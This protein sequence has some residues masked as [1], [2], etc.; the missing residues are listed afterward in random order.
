M[1]RGNEYENIRYRHSQLFIEEG[2]FNVNYTVLRFENDFKRAYSVSLAGK[3]HRRFGFQRTIMKRDYYI[4]RLEPLVKW[5]QNSWRFEKSRNLTMVR[6]FFEASN[7]AKFRWFGRS[8]ATRCSAEKQIETEKVSDIL[9]Y[10]NIN[11]D[12]IDRG[13]EKKKNKGEH[14]KRIFSRIVNLRCKIAKIASNN[15]YVFLFTFNPFLKKRN[16]SLET[17]N[18][19]KEDIPFFDFRFS[20]F[21]NLRLGRKSLV[22]PRESFQFN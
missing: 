18:K 8:D 20:I 17:L 19:I 21:E 3:L 11:F 14:T 5:N 12:N 7:E 1:F 13:G 2:I 4:Q 16:G 15:F 9:S 22:V 6:K 10:N